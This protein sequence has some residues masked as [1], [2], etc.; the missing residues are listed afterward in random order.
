MIYLGT[1]D[2]GN[3]YFIDGNRY[4]IS[5]DYEHCE[6]VDKNDVPIRFLFNEG[7]GKKRKYV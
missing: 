1:D 3:E 6:P 7:K 2:S 4:M 5:N